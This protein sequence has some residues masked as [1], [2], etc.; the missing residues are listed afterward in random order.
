MLQCKT[1]AAESV[2]KG[3]RIVC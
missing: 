1:Q 2:I 3:N